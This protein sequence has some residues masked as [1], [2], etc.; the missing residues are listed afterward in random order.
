MDHHF[1]FISFA[2]LPPMPPNPAANENSTASP[3]NKTLPLSGQ[4]C[5]ADG[6]PEEHETD[7]GLFSLINNFVMGSDGKTGEILWYFINSVSIIQL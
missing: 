7:T 1:I 4:T 5:P 6:C 2:A 3:V